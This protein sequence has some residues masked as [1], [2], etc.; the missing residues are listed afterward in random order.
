MT[1]DEVC[2]VAHELP[3]VE[4]GTYHG[5]PALRVA[6]KFLVRLGDDPGD[7]ELKGL[8][9][10]E[11]EMLVQ[12]APAVFHAPKGL[13]CPFFARLAELDQATLRGVLGARWRRIAPRSLAK[14]LAQSEATRDV[15]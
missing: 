13:D 6:G 10:D 1:W 7:I 8:G 9:F 14:S 2:A 3:A 4:P 11:R 15:R 5:Y 12:S